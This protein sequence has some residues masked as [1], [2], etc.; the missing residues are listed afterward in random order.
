MT[1]E[2]T[3]DSIQVGIRMNKSLHDKLVK[4]QQEAKKMTGFEPSI[5]DVIRLLIERGLD[6]PV[7]VHAA[8]N[9]KRR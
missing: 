9:R 7:V 8:S 3:T 1:T 4:R 6:T 2:E 5:A